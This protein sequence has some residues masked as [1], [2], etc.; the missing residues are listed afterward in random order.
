[1]HE[2]NDIRFTAREL[3]ERIERKIDDS[4][5]RITDRLDAMAAIVNVQHDQILGIKKDVE[6]H[7]LEDR[8]NFAGIRDNLTAWRAE[9]TVHRGLLALVGSGVLGIVI[10]FVVGGAP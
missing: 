4:S 6:L 9:I 1:M 7:A 2:D 8:Q 5:Q 10:K 3:L